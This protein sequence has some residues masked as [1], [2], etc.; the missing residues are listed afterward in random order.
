MHWNTGAC[1]YYVHPQDNQFIMMYINALECTLYIREHLCSYVVHATLCLYVAPSENMVGRIPLILLSLAGS[2]TP[3]IPRIYS[4]HK[5]SRFPMGCADAVV[6]RLDGINVY[7]VKP[8]LWQFGRRK[9][10]LGGL[11]IVETAN[12]RVAKSS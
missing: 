12:K 2:T 1:L 8:W 3:T 10:R 5:D 4:K 11:T 9:P 7:E 6:L